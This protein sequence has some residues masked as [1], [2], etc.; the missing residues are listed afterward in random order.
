MHPDREQRTEAAGGARAPRLRAWGPWIAAGAVLVLAAAAWAVW[1]HVWVRPSL[2][3]AVLT[4]PAPTYDFSLRDQDQRLVRLSALRGKAVAL[5]FLYTHCPDICPLIAN[6]MHETY[7]QL[8]PTAARVAFLAISVDPNGDT[9]ESVRTFL[10]SHRVAGE[11]T[12]LTGSFAELRPVWAHY[13]IGT[14]AK[15][16][17]PGAESVT[18]PSPDLVSHSAI[19]YVLDP[20]GSLRVFLPGNFN[21]QDLATDLRILASEPER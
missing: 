18:P 19:V 11:L 21:P 20:R 3:G 15:E 5:T 12:Y 2:Q 9:P 4:P 10:S 16:V 6:K 1:A 13:Y 17:N 8:G 7:R 14:D